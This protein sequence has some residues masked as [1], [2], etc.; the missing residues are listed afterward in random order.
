MQISLQVVGRKQDHLTNTVLNILV[1]SGSQLSQEAR[2]GPGNARIAGL[3]NLA[4]QLPL[5][6]S[7]YSPDIAALPFQRLFQNK[8]RGGK[9]HFTMFHL[10]SNWLFSFCLQEAPP[11]FK[12]P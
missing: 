3:V 4:K 2:E 6:L 12:S 9:Y 8:Q 11:P 5:H 7:L 1:F 10:M